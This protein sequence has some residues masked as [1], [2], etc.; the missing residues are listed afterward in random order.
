MSQG[1]TATQLSAS[2]IAQL[3]DAQQT[4]ELWKYAGNF[5]RIGPRFKAGDRELIYREARIESALQSN[6]SRRHTTNGTLRLTKP[7]IGWKYGST[8]SVKQAIEMTTLATYGSKRIILRKAACFMPQAKIF[9]KPPKV[10]Q[11]FLRN[12]SLDFIAIGI[13]GYFIKAKRV[14]QFSVVVTDWYSKHTRARPIPEIVALL[15]TTVK[16]EH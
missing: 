4:N 8:K 6:F 13:L 11:L 1:K 10:A 3:S 14:S 12:E 2:I 7:N 5:T 15:M 16:L 9:L